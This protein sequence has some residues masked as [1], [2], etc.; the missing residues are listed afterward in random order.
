M[1]VPSPGAGVVKS[2]KV[3]VRDKVS[4]GAVILLL[5][6]ES[7]AAAAPAPAA[8]QEAAPAKS[9]PAPSAPRASGT[10]SGDGMARSADGTVLGADGPL[11]QMMDFSGVHA[12][13]SVRRLA[14]ELDIDLN[15]VQGTGEK[16]RVTKDDVKGHLAGGSAPQAASAA[17]MARA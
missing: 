10:D 3:K 15:K 11:P 1:D 9:D 2:L 4:E 17:R 5:E 13:P 12:S 7:G 14:R 8:K 6:G 16:G